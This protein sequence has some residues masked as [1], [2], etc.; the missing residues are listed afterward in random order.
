M[1]N[2]ARR[3]TEV[4]QQL[5]TSAWRWAR[6]HHQR[7][8]GWLTAGTL[9]AAFVFL[10]AINRHRWFDGDEWDALIDRSL[11]GGHGR[12]GLLQPHNEHWST[13]PILLY[14]LLFS[15]FAVRTYFPYLLMVILAHLL[16]VGLVWL[17]LR[18]LG[19]DIWVC[20]VAVAA[21]A[22]L[23]AGVDNI[24]FPW[25]TSFTLSVAAGLAALLVA[26]VAGGWSRRDVV[27]WVLLFLGL[28][29]S[30]I[31]LTMVGV[32][33]VVQLLRRGFGIG[34]ATLAVPAIVYVAWYAAYGASATNPGQEPLRTAIQKVPAFVWHGLT[35]PVST[36]LGFAGSGAVVIVLLG[37]WAARRGRLFDGPWPI[38]LGVAVGAAI[39]LSLAATLRVQFGLDYASTPRYSYITLVLLVP[40]AALA[41]DALLRT[42]PLRG[43]VIVAGL[44]L[45][46]LV[47]VSQ[48]K[49]SVDAAAKREADQK[50]KILAT[51]RLARATSQF[52][53]PDPVPFYMLDLTVAKIHALDRSGDLPS[54]TPTSRDH[55]N[56]LEWVQV[57]F[58]PDLRLGTAGTPAAT[59]VAASGV[60][61]QAA[62][63]TRCLSVNARSDRPSVRFALIGPVTLATTSDRSGKLSLELDENGGRGDVRVLPI[64]GSHQTFLNLNAPSTMAV[65][66]VPP[67]GS[68]QFCGPALD[69]A[70][71]GGTQ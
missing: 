56:A 34:L 45:L 21:L 8:A 17:L 61:V 2:I 48:I 26:P 58:G 59:L 22:F 43:P 54:A 65:I 16:V 33:V 25:G 7:I 37:V 32:V 42:V 28:A 66:T 53:Y 31:G 15:V 68:T 51:A 40:I 4:A 27:V 71:P 38:A 35:E 9:G 14:R 46:L 50:G 11:F 47:G 49:M 55:L 52:L 60:S 57:L 10:L 3:Y 69:R 6:C 18:R 12:S 20:F 29:S 62:A 63:T 44:C 64:T 5:L 19:V 39:S 24:V 36:T 41:T 13:L 67:F 30:G 70:T 23:G 1:A